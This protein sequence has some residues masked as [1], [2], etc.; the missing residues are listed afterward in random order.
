MSHS[1]EYGLHLVVFDKGEDGV[2]E[3]RPG[4]R[5][6]V[7]LA[8]HPAAAGHLV[9]EGV[10]AALIGLEKLYHFPVIGLVV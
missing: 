2:V 8:V 7:R 5:A 3:G 6:F 4:V 1:L 9:P 10:A